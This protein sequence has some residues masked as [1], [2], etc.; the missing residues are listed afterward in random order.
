[1]ASDSL[2]TYL[3]DHLGGSM[4]GSDLAEQIRDRS[5]GTPLGEV[6]ATIAPQIEQDRE[7]LKGL[8]EGLGT[9]ESKIKEAGA[10][11]AEKASR[12]KLGGKSSDHVDLDLFMALETLELGVRGKLLL[13]KALKEIEGE[14]P[15]LVDA[16]LDD[17][18]VRAQSQIEA[19]EGERLAAGRQVLSESA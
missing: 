5:E 9:S 13:W 12:L 1:M 15:Q 10:W 8:M 6:M 7:T 3:N 14:H 19:L 2:D 4:L 18:I 17:L 16:G 11:V